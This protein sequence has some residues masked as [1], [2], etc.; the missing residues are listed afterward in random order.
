VASLEQRLA[1]AERDINRATIVRLESSL[2]VKSLALQQMTMLVQGAQANIAAIENSTVWRMTRP[3]RRTLA[4]LPGVRRMARGALH[5]ALRMAKGRRIWEQ[6]SLR[7]LSHGATL[8]LQTHAGDDL[9]NWRAPR[10]TKM[11]VNLIG[12]AEFLNGLSTSFRGYLASLQSAGIPTNVIPWRE[13][14]EHL[15]RRAF[16]SPSI[17]LQPINLVHLN[18]DVLAVRRLLEHSP[19]KNL[20]APARYNVAIVSWELTSIPRGQTSRYGVQAPLPL[21]LYRQSLP[22]LSVLFGLPS[23]EHTLQENERATI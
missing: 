12:P 15:E 5:F 14:F 18:L 10:N 21:V 2:A 11:G 22:D 17:R 13:G 3:L 20:V 7:G 4:R 9:R 19:L 16:R 23:T 6:T 8:E 1:Q